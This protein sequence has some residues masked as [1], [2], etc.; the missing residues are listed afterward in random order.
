MSVK[1]QFRDS[2]FGFSALKSE[3]HAWDFLLSNPQSAI[4]YSIFFLFNH[5]TIQLV[6][7]ADCLSTLEREGGLKR[8]GKAGLLPKP[9][10]PG[11]NH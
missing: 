2:Y 7:T 5:L 1:L 8:K 3:I 6:S 9:V 4:R 10:S 11:K